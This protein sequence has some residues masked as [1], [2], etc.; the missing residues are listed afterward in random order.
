M[1]YI[2]IPVFNRKNFTQMCLS[3]LDKQTYS[4]FRTIVI[5]DGSTDGTSDM[6][7]NDF[8]EVI[9]LNGNG[10]L[11]WTEATNVGIR[12]ALTLS[13]SDGDFI[14]TLNDDLEVNK[15]Y[16][17]SLILAYNSKELCLIGST[18]VD[19]NNPDYLEY[20]GT[21][22]EL[23][24][25]SGYNLASCYAF[26]YNILKRHADNTVIT[27]SLPGRGTLIPIIIFKKLGL[28][29]SKH[30]KQYMADIEFS[31]RCKKAGYPLFVSVDSV[32]HTYVQ[33]TGIQ[34]EKQ[35]TVLEF[36]QGFF[37]TRSSTNIKVRYY[38]A[39]KHSNTKFLYFLLDIG[40]I[41]TGYTLR[42]MKLLN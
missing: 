9:L 14:L 3:C 38:F 42:K 21:K 19:I 15:Y 10:N 11:W 25:A 23:N 5:D 32:V 36:M 7:L 41:V 29:D 37:S 34:I 28:Y 31:V 8:P 30:F 2:V 33:A 12:Y 24:W 6:I 27:D 20:A 18:A 13:K 26:S 4:L 39:M 35:A 1:I 16:L 17:E 40:R 22:S